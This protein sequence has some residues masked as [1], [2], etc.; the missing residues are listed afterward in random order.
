MSTEIQNNTTFIV[1][2]DGTLADAREEYFTPYKRRVFEGKPLYPNLN[3]IYNAFQPI[4]DAQEGVRDLA[5]QFRFGGYWTAR[6]PALLSTTQFWLE[7]NNFPE[8]TNVHLAKLETGKFEL[9]LTELLSHADTS[10]IMIDDHAPRYLQIAKRRVNN[11]PEARLLTSKLVLV[12]FGAPG[13]S[14]G[15]LDLDTGIRMLSLADWSKQSVEALVRD[16]SILHQ[17]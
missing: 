7:R 10:V 16:P 17:R 4:Q 1:N 5:K 11:N 13:R 3:A 9:L 14:E 6:Y 2:L 15:E 12:N 8:P